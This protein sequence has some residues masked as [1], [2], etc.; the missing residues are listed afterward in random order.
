MVEIF[1]L[2]SPFSAGTCC[3]EPSKVTDYQHRI[4]HPGDGGHEE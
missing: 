1:S 4:L 3:D 2:V